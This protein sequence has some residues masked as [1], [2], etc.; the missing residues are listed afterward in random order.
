MATQILSSG[1]T[2]AN[3]SQR[4]IWLHSP[5]RSR[6]RRVIFLVHI[7]VGV[8]AAAYAI[9]IGLSG[10]ALVFTEP[11]EAW[12][13]PALHVVRPTRGQ[14]SLQAVYD[15]V[16]AAHPKDLIYTAVPA[17]SPNRSASLVL[18]PPGKLDRSRILSVYFN[19]YTGAILGER[20]TIQGPLGWARNVHLFLLGGETGVLVN[21]ALGIALVILCLTGMVIWWPGLLRWKRALLPQNRGSW[22]RFNFDL[23]SATGFW[24]SAALLLVSLTGVYIIFPS[25]VTR[26]AMVVTGQGKQAKAAPPVQAALPHTPGAAK[27][28]LDQIAAIGS[29]ALATSDPLSYIL[30]PAGPNG[31]FTAAQYD[32]HAVEYSRLRSAVIDPYSGR[33]LSRSDTADDPLGKRIVAY[34]TAIHFGTF[35]GNGFF[36]TLVKVLWVLLGLAPAVLGVT[37]LVM[38]WNR[39]L[40][41]KYRALRGFTK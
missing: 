15:R 26:V 9:V 18:F 34:C 8:I 28:T 36:G 2:A 38:Y 22:K 27:L 14:A 35:G 31:V 16:Q 25:A 1:K 23:H 39:Y 41:Q 37:G 3:S 32:P 24:S 6:I 10:S 17:A 12:L 21:G 19:P 20:T 33:V 5:Q 40:K 29:K 13:E 7:W 11:L 4:S 30:L